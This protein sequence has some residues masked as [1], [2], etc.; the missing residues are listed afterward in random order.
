MSPCQ[1]HQGEKCW[2][3]DSRGSLPWA[4]PCPALPY[5][6]FRRKVEGEGRKEVQA[7]LSI[8]VALENVGS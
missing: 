5:G 1:S 6:G 2:W 4:L 8:L 7:S 3:A